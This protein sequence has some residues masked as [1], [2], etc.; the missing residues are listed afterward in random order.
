MPVIATG[1]PVRTAMVL[2]QNRFFPSRILD[3]TAGNRINV[4]D[5]ATWNAWTPSGMNQNLIF[6]LVI[7]RPCNTVGIAAHTLASNGA[8]VAVHRSTDGVSWTAASDRYYPV[9]DDDFIL[10]F[11]TG[12]YQYWSLNFLGG[13]FSVGV[14]QGGLRLDFPHS[15]I[16]GYVPL[17]HA[18]KYTKLFNDSVKGQF[19]GNRVMAGG[20][21]T[22]VDMGFFER[23]W[24]E[25]NIAGFEAHYNQGGT[26]FY[27]GCPELYPNDMGYCRA[28]GDDETLAIEFTEADKMAT[29]SFGVRAYVG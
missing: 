11:P 10:T 19:L 18:R 21:E 9:T 3:P 14:A 7:A 13:G 8:S 2:W 23:S 16:P 25:G 26:F 28:K 27:A 24:M 6:D 20:A 12:T 22:D 15:P 4:T 1:T 17:H 29:L 5:P